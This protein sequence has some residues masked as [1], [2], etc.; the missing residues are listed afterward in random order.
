MRHLI[1]VLLFSLPVSGFTQN[2]ALI[3]PPNTPVQFFNFAPEL[4]FSS[5]SELWLQDWAGWSSTL[6]NLPVTGTEEFSSDELL[7][8]CGD[9]SYSDGIYKM[10]T[11][12]GDYSVVEYFYK[13]QFI[14]FINDSYYIGYDGG[15]AFSSDLENWE[16][17]IA[18]GYD[19]TFSYLFIDESNFLAVGHNSNNWFF[20]HSL[21][22]GATWNTNDIYLPINDVVYNKNSDILYVAMGEGFSENDGFLN[23]RI[24][25]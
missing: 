24:M 18:S 10:N 13:P 22:E 25:E 12:T 11:S 7:F 9:G 23:L 6:I 2:W 19:T 1:L 16:T 21:D 4:N 3:S 15:V 14:E 8:V 17:L 5:G 20:M